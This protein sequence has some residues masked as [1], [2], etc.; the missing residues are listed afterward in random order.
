MPFHAIEGSWPD[1][2][3]NET[4][5]GCQRPW[6]MLESAETQMTLLKAC[7]KASQGTG[8]SIS[9]GCAKVFGICQHAKRCVWG[10]NRRAMR[11]PP[12]QAPGVPGPRKGFGPIHGQS[13]GGGDGKNL[14]HSG[15]MGVWQLRSPGPVIDEVRLCNPKMLETLVQKPAHPNGSGHG[16]GVSFWS[17]SSTMVRTRYVPTERCCTRQ[18]GK[19]ISPTC[20]QT[21]RATKM[22]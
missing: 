21:G 3:L 20:G 5:F 1:G 8:P 15:C 6:E 19:P 22:Y 9:H 17:T 4:G 10:Q 14:L 16:R 13:H 12:L 18:T 7:L 2:G 11:L